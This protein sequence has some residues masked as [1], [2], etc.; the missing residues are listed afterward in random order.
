MVHAMG[1]DGLFTVECSCGLNQHALSLSL[2]HSSSPGEQIVS[3]TDVYEAMCY[4]FRTP[5]CP[6]DLRNA[7][8]GP[9][10]LV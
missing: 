8:S 1:T 2:N 9:N 4:R 10:A 7:A 6:E 3:H 5:G